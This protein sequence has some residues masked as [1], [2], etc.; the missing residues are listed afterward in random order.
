MQKQFRLKMMNHDDTGA[1]HKEIT[2][3]KPNND[4]PIIRRSNVNLPLQNEVTPTHEGYS[5]KKS[6]VSPYTNSRKH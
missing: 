2:S 4:L 3:Q 6:N 5:H 1:C